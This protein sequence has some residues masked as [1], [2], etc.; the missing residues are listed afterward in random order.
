MYTNN[1]I[2]LQAEIHCSENNQDSHCEKNYFNFLPNELIFTIFSQLNR[3]DLQNQLEVCK[4]W[5]KIGSNPQLFIKFF[6][7]RLLLTLPKRKNKEDIFSEI[8]ETLFRQYFKYEL[9]SNSKFLIEASKQGIMSNIF[10]LNP[11]NPGKDG[12]LKDFDIE[13]LNNCEKLS[14]QIN[15]E[16]FHTS[17]SYAKAWNACIDSDCSEDFMSENSTDSEDNEDGGG[18]ACRIS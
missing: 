4:V 17:K 15:K 3:S 9:R 8:H 16:T 1:N 2:N 5:K 18:Q 12:Q 7:D 13:R 10:N 11:K 6:H 14:D